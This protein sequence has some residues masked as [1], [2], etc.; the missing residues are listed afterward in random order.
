[1]STTTMII[2]SLITG[3]LLGSFYFGGLWLTIKH[4]TAKS[5]SYHLLFILSF[6]LR[7]TVVVS[8][9][10]LLLQMVH[11]WQAL[12]V[13]LVG[14]LISRTVITRTVSNKSQVI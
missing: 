1:M 11:Q 8:G 3:V 9:F 13:A 2:I 10:F 6:L 5:K 14:F 12:A 7:T 4:F